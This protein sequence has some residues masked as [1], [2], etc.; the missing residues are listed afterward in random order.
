ME[1]KPIWMTGFISETTESRIMWHNIF[2]VLKGKY[3]Q[4]NIPYSEKIFRHEEEIKMFS[5]ERK[6]R[7]FVASRPMN[8]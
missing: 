3:C 1:R 8:G 6:L 7:E 4:P 2:Q 5:D